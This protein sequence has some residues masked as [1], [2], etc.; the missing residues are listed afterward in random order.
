LRLSRADDPATFAEAVEGRVNSMARAHSLLS[1]TRWSGALLGDLVTQE[2]VAFSTCG[3]VDAK[4]PMLA[5][6]PEATQAV[7]LVLHE[8]AT[9]AAKY[10]A[11]AEAAGRLTVTWS[12]GRGPLKLTLVWREEGGPPIAGPPGCHGF[13]MVLIEQVVGGQLS[14]RLDLDWRRDGL[15]CTMTFP[16]DCFTTGGVIGA[17]PEAIMPTTSVSPSGGRRILVVEDEAI[18]ALAIAQTL[19][20]AGFTVLGP[21]ARVA[22]AIDLLRVSVPDAAVLD[23]N[24][25]GSPVDPVVEALS[26]WGVP[27]LFCTGYQDMNHAGGITNDA[28][29][30][31]KPVAA[32]TLVGA[33]TKLMDDSYIAGSPAA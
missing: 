9:N 28:P 27:F 6:R 17:P 31:S 8:L 30:L 33:L 1:A 23:L 18:T 13:G 32:G 24:L 14:G 10:G 19:E 20:Q 29:V 11:L 22:E 16:D 15:C 25:F 4:G 3:R 12:I 5:I 21:A 26:V 2:L 7:A